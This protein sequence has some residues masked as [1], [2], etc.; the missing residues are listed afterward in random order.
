MIP[1]KSPTEAANAIE[2][3]TLPMELRIPHVV[4]TASFKANTRRILAKRGI[5]VKL[6]DA[7]RGIKVKLADAKRE[8]YKG[9]WVTL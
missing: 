3:Y 1:V 2:K 6:A 9:I 5:K 8:E 7:K 4:N